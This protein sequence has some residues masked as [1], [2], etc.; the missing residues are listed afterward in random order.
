MLTIPDHLLK[1]EGKIQ[2]ILMKAE[3][4]H[5]KHVA[6][7]IKF[8]REYQEALIQYI[9]K[10][11]EMVMVGAAIDLGVNPKGIKKSMK[12][13]MNDL[14]KM[15]NDYELDDFI[16]YKAMFSR[17]KGEYSWIPSFLK[18]FNFNKGQA[19]EPINFKG[20]LKYNPVTKK[21]ITN[22]EWKKITA[23][24][25]KYLGDKIGNI[26]EQMMVRAGLFGKLIQS[27]ESEGMNQINIRDMS[28]SDLEKKYGQMPESV[29]EAARQK[30]YVLTNQEKYS[31]DY[32]EGKIGEFLSVSDGKLKNKLVSS[33]RD[34]VSAGI[35]EGANP[36]EIARRLF[37]TDPRDVIGQQFKEKNLESWQRDWRR[38][39]LT[40]MKTAKANGYLMAHK[41]AAPEKKQYFV[42]DGPYSRFHKAGE[43][44][45]KFL[46]KICLLVDEP[47]ASDRVSRKDDP[48][49]DYYIWP[50]KNNIGRKAAS[51]WVCVPIHPNCVHFW[52][53]INP[54]T[55]EW[56]DKIK[57]IVFRED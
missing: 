35:Q 44:C 53:V 21:P 22:A 36:K 38:V 25:I 17:L 56:D 30:E 3:R 26:D 31:M 40:E 33:L 2:S 55:Q 4:N 46:G 37:H 43:S 39:A 51:H 5:E 48:Y 27:M 32:A 6:S 14:M 42:F 50:G 15:A 18:K 54:D 7:K 10:V 24:I 19:L 29:A 1:Y 47:M 49:A 8:E 16:I 20:M 11:A 23:T 13:P 9:E 12:L 57:K 52:T 41:A 34:V 45:N 28:Y